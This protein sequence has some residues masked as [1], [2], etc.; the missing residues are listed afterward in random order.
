[1][2]YEGNSRDNLEEN[3]NVRGYLEEFIK[4]LPQNI[5]V[6]LCGDH[7][8][9][10]NILGAEEDDLRPTSSKGWNLYSR[11]PKEEQGKVA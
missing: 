3:L 8:F 6:C 7:V 11:T 4:N 5:K 1:M 9:Q 10:Q 2:F